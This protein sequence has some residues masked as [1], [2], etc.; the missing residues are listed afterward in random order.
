[1]Q[2]ST[3]LEFLHTDNKELL[4]VGYTIEQLEQQMVII[5][6]QQQNIIDK[7]TTNY[8]TEITNICAGVYSHRSKYTYIKSGVDFLNHIR[9]KCNSVDNIDIIYEH[10]SLLYACEYLL[11][12]IAMT[13]SAQTIQRDLDIDGYVILHRPAII[14]KRIRIK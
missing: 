14:T 5:K 4:H 6:S 7:L 3:L 13:V 2:V 1:M 10:I 12:H 9:T 11:H 8:W